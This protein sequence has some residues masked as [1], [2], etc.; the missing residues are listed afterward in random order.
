MAHDWGEIKSFNYFSFTPANYKNSIIYK[1][2][3]YFYVFADSVSYK[4][5]G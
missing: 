1:M 3:T 5:A 4:M 2:D